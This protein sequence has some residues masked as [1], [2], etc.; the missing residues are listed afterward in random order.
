MTKQWF[1]EQSPL[2]DEFFVYSLKTKSF[3]GVDWKVK[4]YVMYTTSDGQNDF[5]WKKTFNYKEAQQFIEG[6]D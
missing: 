2:K 6:M 5:D 1:I 3:L 4:E